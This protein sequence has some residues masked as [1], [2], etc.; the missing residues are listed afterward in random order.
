[1]VITTTGAREL[2]FT[3]PVRM[4]TCSAPHWRTKSAYFW[5]ESAFSG[6]V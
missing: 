6:V 1:M 3:S 2:T 4:P 5:L